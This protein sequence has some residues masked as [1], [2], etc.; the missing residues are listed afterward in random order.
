MSTIT[1][2]NIRVS[3]DLT[4]RLKLKDGGVAIDWSTLQ[5]IRVSLYADDQRSMAS[6]CNVSIDEEDSTILVCQ[7]AANKMQYLGVNRV[8]VQCKYMGEVKTYDKPAFNFVRWTSDQEGEQITIDDP[9]VDVEI[10]V[11]DV[12]SSILQ[13]AVDAAFDAADRA[14][15]AAAAAEHMVDIHTGPEGKSPYIGENGHWYEW[16]EETHQY[17]DTETNAKGDTGETPD[18]SIGTVTTVEPGTPAAAS[19]GGTPEAPVLNLSIPKGAVGAT[20]NFT[21]GTVTT[22]QPGTPVVITI[23]GTA[24]A[25][26]L[27]VT[28][29]QGLKGDTGVS[30]DYPI[31]IHNGLDSDATD[32]ALAAFQGKVLDGKVSQLEAKLIDIQTLNSDG[33]VAFSAPC[34][35]KQ[36]ETYIFK[37]ISAED[38]YFTLNARV[39][40]S[41][42]NVEQISPA[43]GWGASVSF[44]PSADYHFVRI[45]ASYQG[46]AVTVSVTKVGTFDYRIKELDAELDVVDG[47]VDDL[48]EEKVIPFASSIVDVEHGGLDLTTGAEVVTS[49]RCRTGFLYLKGDVKILL[50]SGILCSFVMYYNETTKAFDHYVTKNTSDPT[51]SPSTGMI[52]R[53]LF[54]KNP[55]TLSISPSDVKICVSGTAG[56]I[57]TIKTQV[58]SLQVQVAENTNAISNIQD[59][60]NATS[61]PVSVACE[62]LSGKTYLVENTSE[63]GEY[64]SINT[65]ETAS[66]P[67]VEQ[68]SPTL[69][70]G[71]SVYF[72][73]TTTVHFLRLTAPGG[74]YSGDKVGKVSVKLMSTL[75]GRIEALEKETAELSE[76]VSQV[77]NVENTTSASLSVAC[78]M[79]A[80]KTYLVT[81]TS[82][83]G[84]YFAINTR[85]TASGNN[86]EQISSTLGAGASVLFTPTITAHFLRLTA[87]GGYSGSDKAGKVSVKL[88]STID[89]R[90]QT[91]EEKIASLEETKRVSPSVDFDFAHELLSFIGDADVF[92]FTQ[93]QAYYPNFMSQLYAKFDALVSAYPGYVSRVDL[94]EYVGLDYPAY[95]T[96]YKTYMYI[97][98]PTNE[99]INTTSTK[100]RKALFVGGEHSGERV[101]SYILWCIAKCLCESPNDDYFKLRNSMEIHIIPVL[102]GYGSIHCGETGYPENLG[103]V[104]YNGV[105]IN[106]NYPTPGWHV[107]GT[108]TA[109]YSGAEAGSEFE[110]QLVLE[111]V[112]KE[113]YDMV[114]DYHSHVE[115][116]HVAYF[117]L[118]NTPGTDND[119]KAREMYSAATDISI[120]FKKNYPQ[121]YGVGGDILPMGPAPHTP[122]AANGMQYYCL[123]NRGVGVAY[124]CEC[125]YVISFNNGT[126]GGGWHEYFTDVLFSLDEYLF[127]AMLLRFADWCLRHQSLE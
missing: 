118:S 120:T 36:G 116:E 115:T 101:S 4:I 125:P 99:A 66:G 50:P 9:D 5:N 42:S 26:V 43:L 77:Q 114:G 108:G 100:L 7:Y 91:A 111:V 51:I 27:N 21:V 23:T 47:K 3:S 122:N 96:G 124:L 90:L 126:H 80:G 57:A 1:L 93:G 63:H 97:F 87:P 59:C 55:N 113:K 109:D 13:E 53:L 110:T 38:T 56:E 37:N 14:N 70:A 45:G 73:P 62:M 69:G 83:H 65:R 52:I 72:T 75:D 74:D 48:T 92:G 19:M 20:P 67:N 94:A 41:G 78:E 22:G 85:E 39:T 121:Y 54:T 44:T 76:Q 68:I 61:G 112:D 88:M 25:P 79:V 10:S 28:I 86:V 6:R 119:S 35:L 60:E 32:E 98:R 117:D 40:A 104:N 2:P 123:A 102:E 30:A 18:I 84:E 8:I 31:T 82:E 16:D 46:R 33:S 81:N 95:A 89:G 29:P 15:D 34:E 64:F 11:E 127:R 58:A 24:E 12:S 71:Q 17:V 105:N 107:S 49:T 103:R 106:R